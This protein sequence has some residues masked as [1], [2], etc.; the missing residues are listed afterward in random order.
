MFDTETLC[1]LYLELRQVLPD[2]C[3]S[4]RETEL[5]AA[6]EDAFRRLYGAGMLGGSDDLVRKALR[7][8]HA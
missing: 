4:S 1:K 6:L 5:E 8:E 7:R 3:K 2:T